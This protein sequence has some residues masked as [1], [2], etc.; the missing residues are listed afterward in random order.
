MSDLEIT[1]YVGLGLYLLFYVT[2]LFY[3]AFM[4]IKEHQEQNKEALGYLWYGVAP[5]FAVA[6]VFDIIFNFVWGTIIFLEPPKELL[7][8]ARCS[9]HIKGAGRRQRIAYWLC[10]HLLNPYDKDHCK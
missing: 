5:F 4:H 10:T 2:W 3:V 7:F 9:R 1:L 6:L 8:T